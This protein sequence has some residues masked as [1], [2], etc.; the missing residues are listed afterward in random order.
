[1]NARPLP[2]FDSARALAD[3]EREH[4][5]LTEQYLGDY[6]RAFDSGA[7]P[8][9]RVQLSQHYRGLLEDLAKQMDVL[10]RML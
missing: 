1:M 10:R 3:L 9:T 5:R 6:R 7:T 8:A 4:R 2:A